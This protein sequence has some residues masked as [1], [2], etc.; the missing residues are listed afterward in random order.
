MKK[1]VFLSLICLLAV[2]AVIHI[3]QTKTKSYYSGDAVSFNDT[4]YVSSTNTGSLEIFKLDNNDL[5]LLVKKR[6]FD[7]TFNRYND[8]YDAKLTV[9]NGHLFVYTIS[10]YTI[11]KFEL[12]NDNELQLATSRKNTYWEWYNRVDKFGD[13]IITTSARGVKILND[14]LDVIDSFNLDTRTPYNLRATGNRFIVNIQDGQLTVL[15]R[16][17]RTQTTSIALDYKTNPGNHQVYQDAGGQI[18]V[19]DDYYAKKYDLA[20]SLQGSFRHADYAGFDVA[21]SGE[22]DA[23]YFSDGIG[24]VKLNKNSMNLDDYAY[25]N[26]LG[27]AGGWAMGLKVV[28]VSGSDKVIIFNNTNILVLDDKL[29]KLAAASSTEESEIYATEN[30]FLN[31]NR[32][33][34]APGATV[35]LNGGGYLPNEKLNINFAGAKTATQADARGRFTQELTVPSLTGGAVAPK[36]VDIKVDGQDSKLSYSISF[37][38]Q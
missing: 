26:N 28:S 24:V 30:L 1:I 20:G 3:G 6:P 33:F 37:N 19:V 35:T 21:A 14:D 13:N 25:T 36:A 5:K 8:F 9:E 11:Y 27:G 18:Y 22:N 29:Q 4:V 2:F 15:D 16:V 23:I 7:A 12:V 32:G 34:G 31:L 10:G 17:S 38:I